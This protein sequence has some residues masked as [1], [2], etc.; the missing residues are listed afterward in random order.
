MTTKI[1][2]R[3]HIAS[4]KVVLGTLRTFKELRKGA[5]EQIYVSSNCP[6]QVRT[7]LQRYCGLG[8]TN[9]TE[10]KFSNV[11]LGEICKKP[12]SVSVLGIRKGQ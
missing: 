11:E 8:K 9:C 10:L 2:I 1:D 5:L 12:F 3:K 6:A 7:R 4:K